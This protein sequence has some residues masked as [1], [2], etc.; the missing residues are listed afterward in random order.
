MGDDS[1]SEIGDDE[2]KAFLESLGRDVMSGG[3][4][5]QEDGLSGNPHFFVIVNNVAKKH[6]VGQM[7]RSASAF[8]VKSM[9][10]AGSPKNAQFFGAQGTEKKVN[11]KFFGKVEEAV[12]FARIQQKCQIVGVEIKDGARSISE[13]P[14][15]PGQNVAFMFGNEGSGLTEAQCAKCD[16]FVYIPQFGD[17]TASLNV[18]VAASIVF[19]RFASWAKYP[20]HARRG[21]KFVIKEIAPKRGIESIE[22]AKKHLAR[23]RERVKKDAAANLDQTHGLSTA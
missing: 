3:D 20:E 19:H 8:G 6:N 13:E 7:V 10:I 22:D 18:A 17:G 15:H 4:E 16:L 12:E 1:V 5:L 2:A 11:I 9:L 23:Q 14:F 21:E